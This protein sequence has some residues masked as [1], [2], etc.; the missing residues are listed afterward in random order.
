MKIKY[1]GPPK[2]TGHRKGK[3]ELWLGE[4]FRNNYYLRYDWLK[5]DT[6]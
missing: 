5:G 3:A 1:K 4:E 2:F 6:I